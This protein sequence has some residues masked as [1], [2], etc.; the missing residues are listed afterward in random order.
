MYIDSIMNLH[1]PTWLM[2]HDS[3]RKGSITEINLENFIGKPELLK[4]IIIMKKYI[5]N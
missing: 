4:K 1:M 2:S 3:E 5:Y